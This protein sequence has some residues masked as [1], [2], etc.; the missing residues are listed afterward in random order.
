MAAVNVEIRRY[1]ALPSGKGL[2]DHRTTIN[3]TSARRMPKG[4]SVGEDVLFKL[5]R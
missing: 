1:C 2:R 4:A 3:T 5:L